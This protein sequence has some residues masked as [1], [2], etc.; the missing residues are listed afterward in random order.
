MMNN[1]WESIHGWFDFSFLYDE[2]VASAKNG[3]TI[4]EVGTWLGK[5][6][7]YLAQKIKERGINVHFYACDI[8]TRPSPE[9]PT[10]SDGQITL[11]D[12][13]FYTMFLENIKKQGVEDIVT[14]IV[15]SSLEFVKRFGKHSVDFLFLDND[16]ANEHVIQEL[17]LWYPRVK[18]GS[19]MAGHDAH[20]TKKAL[21]AYKIINDKWTYKIR[22]SCWESKI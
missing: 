9:T 5:S 3:D 2:V 21:E 12:L 16:H 20:E 10:W 6:T 15:E 17:V 1:H 19:I 13:S 11:T 7:C 22:G 14:P 18:P 8:F 4:I